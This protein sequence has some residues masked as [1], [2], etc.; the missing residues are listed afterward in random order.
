[1]LLAGDAAHIHS[2][3]GG[4]GMNTGIGDAFN[5]G[6][7]LSLVA[8]KRASVRL[9]DTYQAERRPVAADVVK[10]TSRAWDMFLGRTLF[11]RLFRDLLFLTVMR[12]PAFQRRWVD[13]GSQ[14]RVTYRGGPLARPATNSRLRPIFGHGPM[15]GDRGPDGPCRLLPTDTPTTLGEQA[16]ARWTLLLFG[17]P[18]PDQR[19]CVQAARLCLGDDLQVFS[20]RRPIRNRKTSDARTEPNTIL[21]DHLGELSRAYHASRST[22]ILLRPDGHVA[23]RSSR[24]EVR[25][26]VIWLRAAF[27]GKDG[28]PTSEARAS[29]FPCGQ[30]IV[31]DR[32][33]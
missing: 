31:S 14:L 5:L 6:W 19:S 32:P 23:W 22:T 18:E 4:Q 17:G 24:P 10:D 16:R 29:A 3:L 20:I 12:V 33:K 7:K 21:E 11:D 30:E 13:S 15:A 27:N 8:Q 9:L 25:G 2:A 26:L 1:M 28:S